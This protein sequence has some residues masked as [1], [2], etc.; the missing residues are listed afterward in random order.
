[1][2]LFV[3]KATY[4]L[5]IER[6][7]PGTASFLG[8]PGDCLLI[9]KCKMRMSGISSGFAYFTLCNRVGDGKGEQ[10]GFCGV[11]MCGQGMVH[12]VEREWDFLS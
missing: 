12:D 4:V 5:L 9:A 6:S 1:M 8:F 10:E 7:F 2:D 3:R 11:F